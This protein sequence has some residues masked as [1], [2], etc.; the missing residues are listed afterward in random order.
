MEKD[1]IPLRPLSA[2]QKH[3]LNTIKAEILRDEIKA[4]SFKLEDTLISLPFSDK[5]DLF[6]LMEKDFSM[7]YTGKDLFTNLR[8]EAEELALKKCEK[9]GCLTLKLIYNILMKKSKI[10]TSS[11]EKLMKR[12]IELITYFSFN[13]NCGL[14]LFA[15]AKNAG[16]FIIITSSSPL[17]RDVISEILENCGYAEHDLL[18]VLNECKKTPSGN[19]MC[20]LIG[21]KSGIALPLTMH[22]G[23]DLS[24]DVEEPVKLGMKAI[25]LSPTTPL[26]IKSGRLRGFIEKQLFYTL[27]EPKYLV[28]K[29]ILALYKAYAFDIPQNKVVQSDFCGDDYLIGFIVLGPLSLYKDF[30]ISSELDAV[31]LGAMSENDNIL[32][33][34]DD[35]SA[36]FDIHFGDFLSKFGFEGCDLP[37]RFFMKHAALKDRMCL[38]KQLSADIME[39]WSGSITEPEL[40]PVCLKRTQ[41]SNLSKLADRLFQPGSHIRTIVDRI[42]DKMR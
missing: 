41:K 6:Q 21:E 23:G 17:S 35:F 19:E 16:K 27:S 24:N 38:Q 42:I 22:I 26:M 7:L 36:M 2:D 9:K 31:I 1:F 33:G 14:E 30:I 15:E 11:C 12:E 29:C 20:R 40:A 13:R 10:S 39:K 8:T 32:K 25:F 18:I 34:R 3:H 5:T 28:L 4:V 37:F